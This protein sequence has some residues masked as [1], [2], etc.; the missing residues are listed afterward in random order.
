MER[1]NLT[2]PAKIERVAGLDAPL[3]RAVADA[4]FLD[5]PPEAKSVRLIVKDG[6]NVKF[7]GAE[8][9]S[10][11]GNNERIRWEEVVLFAVESGEFVAARAWHSNVDGEESFWTASEVATVGDAMAAWNWSTM[12]K[13]IA[14]KLKW[15]IALYVGARP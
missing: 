6:P 1:E 2:M 10:N 11:A 5:N 4:G 15:D 3:A 7:I 8:I 13:G 12:A 9:A 14:K